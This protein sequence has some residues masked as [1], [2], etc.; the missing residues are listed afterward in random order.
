[1]NPKAKIIGL[2]RSFFYALRGIAYCV[3]SERNMR[4]HLCAVFYIIVFGRFYAFTLTQ[5]ALLLLFIALVIAAEMLNTAIEA[6]V[7]LTSPCYNELA[8]KSK[9]IAAGAVFVC[10]LAAFIYGLVLFWDP[11]KFVEIFRFYRSNP[12]HSVLLLLSIIAWIAFI[13]SAKPSYYQLK[14]QAPNSQKK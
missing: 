14:E 10:A 1:M 3:K 11:A 12:E 13:Y 5:K 7:D 4:I 2:L 6:S 9:D 8:K